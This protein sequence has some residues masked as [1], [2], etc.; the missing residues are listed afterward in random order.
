[1]RS[2]HQPLSQ[3]LVSR[4]MTTKTCGELCNMKHNLMMWSKVWS[5]NRH[6]NRVGNITSCKFILCVLCP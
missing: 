6:L 3:L 1:M 4:H 5:D 2:G